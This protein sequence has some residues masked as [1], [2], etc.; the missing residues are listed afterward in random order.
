MTLLSTLPRPDED[1]RAYFAGYFDAE[2]TLGVFPANAGRSWCAR[3]NFGQTNA[4]V[5]H[6]LKIFYG[7]SLHIVRRAKANWQDKTQWTLARF[8]AVACFL[9]D[10]RPF[11]GEKR[12]QVEAVLQRFSTRMPAT[13]ARQLIADLK[14]MKRAELTSRNLPTEAKHAP[15]RRRCAA[16]EPCRRPARA[17]GLCTRH[18]QRA[19][20]ARTLLTVQ[21]GRG[22]RAHARKD[23]AATERAY[24]AGYFD[25]DGSLD[26][27]RRSST[28]HLAIAFNQTRPEA[29]LRLVASY[30]G[31]LHFR[32]K[33][34]PRRN[35]LAWTLT[36][37]EAVLAFLRDVQ[38]YVI[39]KQREVAA[40]LERYRPNMAPSEAADLV[41]ELIRD[42]PRRGG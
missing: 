11:V 33:D 42:R 7:G 3:V 25:G 41:A 31:R 6:Q 5:L 40:V 2:G 38:P 39:E 22:A 32:P 13:D 1:R 24:F 10:I 14:Q 20:A 28:W 27:R 9:E 8:N 15:K 37:R 35:Q 30:G 4:D 21:P 18:Y 23:V 34:P 16:D 26:L 29:L 17:Q 12:A 19:R 36:Q